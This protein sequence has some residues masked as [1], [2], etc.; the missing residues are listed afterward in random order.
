MRNNGLDVDNQSS[1][2][3]TMRRVA[4]W[5]ELRSFGLTPEHFSWEE[6]KRAAVAV[7]APLALALATG[8]HFIGWAIFAAFW[9]CLC[10]SPGPN[11]HRRYFL[12]LFVLF[13]TG[14]TFFGSWAASFGQTVAI[15]TGPSL[16]LICVL[17]P[18]RLAHSSMLATLLAVVGVVAVGYPK[19][20]EPAALQALAFFGGSLWAYVLINWL[21]PV[22]EWLPVRQATRAV[23]MRLTDMTSDL[24]VNANRPH[25][26]NA[27]HSE[28]ATHRRSVRMSIER[29]RTL[30][31]RYQ[32]EPT[33]R[34]R[35]F[36]TLRDSGEMIFSA[37][38]A[39]DHSFILRKG[40]AEDRVETA[41]TILH[42]LIACRGALAKWSIRDESFEKAREPLRKA[43]ET[44]QD[45]TLRGCLMAVEQAVLRHTLPL[46]EQAGLLPVFRPAAQPQTPSLKT[47]LQ[48]ALRQSLGVLAVYYVAMLFHF[49]YPYWATMAVVVV[50]QGAARVTWTRGMERIFGSLLGGLLTVGFLHIVDA[51]WLLSLL[52]VPLAGLTIALRGVNYTIF[53]VILTM[54]FIMVTELLQPGAGVASARMLDNSI[55]SLTALVAVL[56]LW[57][58]LGAP[59]ST[60]ISEGLKANR[61]YLNAVEHASDEESINAARRAAGLASV[62]AEVALH[63]LGGLLRRYH[64]VAEK[65]ATALKELRFLA[66]EAAAAWHRRLAQSPET[67]NK[68]A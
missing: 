10:D 37:L 30:L 64:R 41:I 49:G 32:D 40:R 65:E 4:R 59:L 63:D 44:M 33:E 20:W 68:E 14:I 13:G 60:L 31:V 67:P 18:W 61:A 24:V 56:V 17:L 8:Q 38:I 3:V 9:T 16:V 52:V 36:L 26:D 42:M 62:N 35:P 54:L 15:I 47:A 29:L 19:T 39:L 34:L 28:H 25:R 12:L 2:S 57:P 45:D 53:V 1:L 7:A 5:L 66:G 55:G 22:D 6:A 43:I 51:P 11:R 48:H 46:P 58:D 50:L 27:W 23:L 21:M